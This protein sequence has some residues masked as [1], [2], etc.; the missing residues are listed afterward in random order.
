MDL[1]I[2]S[3]IIEISGLLFIVIS[4]F[5]LA[6]QLNHGNRLA[7]TESMSDAVQCIDFMKKVK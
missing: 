3:L 4:V 5:Y 6:K 2:L 7:S 1:Q